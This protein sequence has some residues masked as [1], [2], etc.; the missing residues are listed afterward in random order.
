MHVNCLTTFDFVSIENVV[1]RP[2]QHHP[3]PVN[4]LLFTTID[5]SLSFS[6]FSFL[7][8]SPR[9]AKIAFTDL[10]TGLSSRCT[11]PIQQQG[12][13]TPSFNS[14]INRTTCSSRVCCRFTT[15]HQQIHSFRASGVSFFHAFNA[16]LLDSNA[17][18][19]SSGNTC[20][21][22]PGIILDA[23]SSPLTLPHF[24]PTFNN[25]F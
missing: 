22:P 7:L 2:N 1:S 14:F 8:P 13:L 21:V 12:R 3:H 20:T 23:I 16:T 10:L 19:I 11:H 5:Y 17:L 18:C 6:S 15:V 24:A 4:C 25:V 9:R